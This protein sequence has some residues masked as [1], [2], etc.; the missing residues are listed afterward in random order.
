MEGR[1]M[2]SRLLGCCL[3]MLCAGSYSAASLAAQIYV[4]GSPDDP[5]V[6]AAHFLGSDQRYLSAVSDLLRVQKGGGNNFEASPEYWTDLA[7]FELSFGMR[8]R[9][10]Q[11]YRTV[12]AAAADPLEGGRARLR[13]ARFEYERG[14]LD[15]A[16]ASLLR[17]RE[18]LPEELQPEWGDLY[19]RVLMAQGRYNDAA[20]A[21]DRLD[22]RDDESGF[23]RYNLGVALIK[24]G[25]LA[26]GRTSLDRVGRL[27]GNTEEIASLRDKANVTLGWHFLQNQLGGSARP[28]LLRVRSEGP[29]SNRAL[30]GLGWVEIAP[31]GRRQSR[32]DIGAEQPGNGELRSNDDPL[33]NFSALGVLLRRGYLDDPYDRA[34]LRSFRRGA[35]AKEEEEGLRRALVA[36]VELLDRDPQDPAVQEAW[37]AV[38]F[39]LDKLGAHTQAVQYYEQAATRLEEAR[40]RTSAAIDAVKGGRMVETMARAQEDSEAGWMWEVRDLADAPETYYLQSLIADHPFTEGLKNYRDVRL[41]SRTLEAWGG[42]LAQMD[43]AWNE[44]VRP[45]SDPQV[46]FAR[47]KR[48]WKPPREKLDVRMVEEPVLSAPGRYSRKPDFSRLAPVSL[49]LS[50]VPAKFD[51]SWERLQSL[52]SRTGSLTPILVNARAEGARQ[53]RKLALTELTAQ[54]AQIDR[55]LVETRFSLA[56]IYDRALPDADQDEF[57]VKGDKVKPKGRLQRGEV[58]IDKAKPLPEQ[59]RK[60]EPKAKPRRV[61]SPTDEYEVK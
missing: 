32:S 24:D 20:A 61:T 50:A 9:A 23:L 11:V 22:N 27:L 52:K 38:P 14:Y 5:R 35:V 28:L 47:A 58:D 26:D 13:L 60:P 57:D 4:P 7:E 34:G 30:L 3:A 42:R 36:W 17:A 53:L 59:L 19:A 37:L 44:A 45:A 12:S 6:R 51:G 8:D 43:K 15:E 2:K 29:Y 56:R 10:E 31:Q 49:Q 46:L 55:Y 1:R 25:R 39:A 41:M 48:S 33:S 40:K 18:K 54:K 16:R 21:L